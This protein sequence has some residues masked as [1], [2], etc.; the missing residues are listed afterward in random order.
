VKDDW[1][2]LVHIRECI[3]RIEDYTVNGRSTFMES[4][5]IQDAVTRNL[6]TMAESTQRLSD[7]LKE[8]HPDV[9]WYK[10]AG[11]RTV[12]VHDYLAVDLVRVWN[13]VVQD[14]PAFKR[15]ALEILEGLKR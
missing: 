13:A 12:L 1:L 11:L 9:Q 15:T 2:Y 14:L 7:T 10:I 8:D 3:E 6:Q 5:L 4:P